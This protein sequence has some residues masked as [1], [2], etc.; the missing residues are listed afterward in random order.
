METLEI[1]P[2]Y[3]SVGSQSLINN[4]LKGDLVVYIVDD[5][6]IQVERGKGWCLKGSGSGWWRGYNAAS[7][8]LP[9]PLELLFEED[10]KMYGCIKT[11][12]RSSFK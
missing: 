1:A 4:H 2:L 8:C 10:A 9:T 12:K 5:G 11:L 6:W 7:G 3:V